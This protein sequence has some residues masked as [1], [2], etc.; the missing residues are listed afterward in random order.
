[1][2]DPLQEDTS[3]GGPVGAGDARAHPTA[4]VDLSATHGG[5]YKAAR[6]SLGA[7][8]TPGIRSIVG[9]AATVVDDVAI[10]SDVFVARSV[11]VANDVTV[12]DGSDIGYASTIGDAAQLGQGVVTVGPRVLVGDNA[13][14]QCWN[15]YHHRTRRGHRDWGD[16]GRQGAHPQ[17]NH[18]RRGG[19]D[20]QWR[21]NRWWSGHWRPHYHR[22]HSSHPRRGHH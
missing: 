12:G 4:T 2:A 1:V 17:G 22:C 16:T 11:S 5:Q 19:H 21:A 18:H 8:S 9:R 7:W 14:G 3:P 10:G 6:S 13:R 15:G 20:C